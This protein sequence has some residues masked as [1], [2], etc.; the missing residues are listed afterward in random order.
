MLY[1]WPVMDTSLVVGV[2]VLNHEM[3]YLGGG[4]AEEEEPFLFILFD[5]YSLTCL[6]L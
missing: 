2:G 3:R 4:G 5:L 1:F 6:W